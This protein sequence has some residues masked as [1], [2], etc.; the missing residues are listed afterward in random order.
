MSM[1]KKNHPAF[2]ETGTS[3]VCHSKPAEKTIAD[4]KIA[5]M[6]T[7]APGQGIQKE[8]LDGKKSCQVTFRLPKTAA[9]NGNKVF[10]VGDFNN[11]NIHANQMKK[12][13]NGDHAISL[14][15]ASGRE[16]QFRYLIDDSI[17]ENDW[18]AD[19]YVKSPYGNC[20]NS[21]VIV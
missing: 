17:W 14:S 10:I 12:Q 13:K 6:E 9:P 19:K 7:T 4:E 11:W 5:F 18:K 3:V 8:Y 21:V 20:D 2:H 15:L 1:K 16:Y